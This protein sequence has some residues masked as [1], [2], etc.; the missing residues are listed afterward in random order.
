MSTNTCKH[1]YLVLFKG[2]DSDFT[3][4]QKIILK[5]ETELDLTGCK[6]HFR[7]LDFKQDFNEIPADKTLELVF[8]KA[9]TSN[10][11]T[12]AMDAELWL[13]DSTGKRRTVANRIHI[14]VTLSVDAAYDNDDPQAITVVITSGSAESVSWNN[15]T[16]KPS[17]FP[18]SAHTHPISQVEGLQ[19]ELNQKVNKV[20]G[21]TAG[22]LAS[23]TSDGGIQ[24]SGESVASLKSYTD[25]QVATN[26]AN[27]LGTYDYAT[28]L[29]F[30]PPAT[31]ADVDNDE[32]SAA[33]ATHVS[34]PS[35]NDYVFVV[36]NYTATTPADEFRRFKYNATDEEWL[37]EYT[38][39][40]ASFTP[41]QWAAINS[42]IT[43]VVAPSS[44]ATSGQAASAK[45]T[46]DALA[47]RPT[48]AQIDAGWWS[49]WAVYKNGIVQT[50]AY[51]TWSS[52]DWIL[53]SLDGIGF[54]G[55]GIDATD[56]TF[57]DPPGYTAT[58]HRVAAPVPMKPE[59]IG[60][61]SVADATLTPI[62]SQTPTF[63]EWTSIPSGYESAIEWVNNTW[64][65]PGNA[66]AIG[67][68]AKDFYAVAINFDS[69]EQI[70]A[71]RVRTDIIGYTLG[72]Q[73]DKP[74]QPKGDYALLSQLYAAVRNLAPDFTAKIYAKND[75]CTYNGVFYRCKSA[76]TATSSSAK[77]DEDTTHWEAKKASEL[78]LP[79]TG[80][81]V[82]GGIGV[83]GSIGMGLCAIVND[84]EAGG[85]YL[86]D[87]TDAEIR[88]FFNDI[89]NTANGLSTAYAKPSDIGIPAFSSSAIYALNA[90]VVY[91]NAL[92][93]CTT[94]VS[95]A[96][97]WNAANWTKIC[98]LATDATP[99]ANS[100]ALMTSGDIKTALDAKADASKCKYEFN[101][102]TV[103]LSTTTDTDDTAAVTGIVDHAK[104]AATLVS[105][106]TA[107][108]ITIPARTDG[109]TGDLFLS[110]TVEGSAPSITFTDAATSA[111]LEVIF[112]SAQLADIDTGRNL[113]LFSEV[114]NGKWKVAVEHEDF[115]E[116]TP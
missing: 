33:L 95:T 16:G 80:G 82:T 109:Y 40:S 81:H 36:V 78:F 43:G 45:A 88:A 15:I 20:E 12:G 56:L 99:T 105:T 69:P 92:W 51:V 52:P 26:T 103:T 107:A 91:N 89:I 55:G 50:N 42:G 57:G 97:A 13:E 106:V 110:L 85:A 35:N 87:H 108:T 48:K 28:D 104:N 101:T 58:R 25:N 17:T 96:G 32:I 66:D 79:L 76:Y 116:V 46:D 67:S 90:K 10:F 77:P 41:A 62:Y 21:A 23:L 74:L 8:P 44:S 29:G 18:P 7:F 3:G 34:N 39:N 1:Q 98:D 30:T 19:A 71:T 11:P 75:L 61:A 72:S 31:S 86:S 70:T 93:N 113:I 47:L 22:N 114:E 100:K 24:N 49:E 38:L 53:T 68:S 102:A 115:P 63:S 14:V 84:A 59:D 27:F 5:L 94:A 64:C 6:A 4:N 2:D 65:S 112:G 111:D 9:S 60:A 54:T 37:Y 73:S 83:S